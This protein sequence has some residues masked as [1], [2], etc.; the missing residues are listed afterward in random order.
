[1]LRLDLSVI[2]F[3]FYLYLHFV[4]P[5]PLLFTNF[6]ALSVYSVLYVCFQYP[7]IPASVARGCQQKETNRN[8]GRKE[9]NYLNLYNS[10]T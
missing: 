5:L 3:Y 1:M 8:T 7:L 4:L 2:L 6:Y 10:S 9:I